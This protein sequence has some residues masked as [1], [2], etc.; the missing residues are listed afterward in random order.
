[1]SHKDS[2]IV[3]ATVYCK[4]FL[5]LWLVIVIEIVVNVNL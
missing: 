2:F 3:F 1:M 4:V 5:L